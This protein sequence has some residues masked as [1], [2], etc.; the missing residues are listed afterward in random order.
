MFAITDTVAG[1][2]HRLLLDR[3]SVPAD[4]WLPLVL[5]HGIDLGAQ[6][7]T[8]FGAYGV[9]NI[10]AVAV[11]D[12]VGLVTGRINA[13]LPDPATVWQRRLALLD[14]CQV[15]GGGGHIAFAKVHGQHLTGLGNVTDHGHKAF[16]LLVSPFGVRLVA[17]DFGRIDIQGDVFCSDARPFAARF[18]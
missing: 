13:Q 5:F 17:D 3:F 12:N 9:F 7:G 14:K 15:T 18:D 1:A 10:V 6:V 11:F 2:A 8:G 4:Q 16:V